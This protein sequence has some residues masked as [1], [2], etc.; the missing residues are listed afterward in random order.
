[1]ASFIFVVVLGVLLLFED[2]V[3]C[4]RVEI[5]SRRIACLLIV[6]VSLPFQYRRDE[7]FHAN[8]KLSHLVTVLD[9]RE[10]HFV[11]LEI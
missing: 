7:P 10:V 5:V 8:Q 3:V 6:A 1:M 2:V 4:F 9:P 11:D